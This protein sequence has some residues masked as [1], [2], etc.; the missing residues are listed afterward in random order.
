MKKSL[1]NNVSLGSM[2]MKDLVGLKHL[3][4]KCISRITEYSARIKKTLTD[5]WN[6]DIVIQMQYFPSE[7]AI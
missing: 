6:Q 1:K 5:F 2:N 3:V 4:Q 7:Q